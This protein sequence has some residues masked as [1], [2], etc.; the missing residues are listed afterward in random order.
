MTPPEIAQARLNYGIACEDKRIRDYEVYLTYQPGDWTCPACKMQLDRSRDKCLGCGSERP[1]DRP[2][3]VDSFGETVTAF[4]RIE[5]VWG[6]ASVLK[7][8]VSYRNSWGDRRCYV[9]FT[10]D[11][12]GHKKSVKP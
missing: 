8:A 2:K 11:C 1:A 3:V 10:K 5:T 6:A 12:W 4:F 7:R 9:D